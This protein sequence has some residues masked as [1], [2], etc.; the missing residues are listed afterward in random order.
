MKRGVNTEIA[1]THILARKKQTLVASLGVTIGITAFVFLNSLILGFTRFFD[2][3][4]FKSMPHMRI[5]KDD[6]IS[7][8]LAPNIYKVSTGVVINPKILNEPKNLINPQELLNEVKKQNDVVAAAQW[9]TVN[10]FY[11]SGRSQISGVASGASID[12]ADAMFDI[13]STMIDGDASNLQNVSNGILLGVGIAEKLNLRINDNVTVIS[14]LGA[15]KIMKVVGIFKT[16]NSITDK[17][18]SYMN[19]AAAQQLMREG[20]S[21]VTDIYVNVKDPHNIEKYTTVFEKLS[22][23][24]VENWKEANETFVAAGKTRNVMMRSISAAILLVAAFGIYNILNMTIMQKLNDIAILKATGFSGKDVIKIFVSEAVIMGAF[25]TIGG[26]LL[27]SLLVNLVSHVYVGGDIG[28]FPIRW[29][30]SIITLG[31]FIGLIVTIGA[32]LIPARNAA[33]VDPVEIFR[34]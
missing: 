14:S 6:A 13:T 17:S 18:K 26:L 23:Y 8:P 16:S 5:Y 19:L 22:G 28:Y 32:G 24:K 2:N 29:E 12:E 34:R 11:T 31:A 10:L 30:P 1:L 20:P 3:S 9:V 21:Y 15:S 4:I 27:A 7:Q 25:G 33:K